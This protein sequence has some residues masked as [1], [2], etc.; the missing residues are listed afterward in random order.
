MTAIHTHIFILL[1][2][3]S[4]V[5]VIW[6]AV[7]PIHPYNLKHF[8]PAVHLRILHRIKWLNNSERWTGKMWPNLKYIPAF[9]S[10]HWGKAR[11]T[12]VRIFGVLA[13]IRTRHLPT[14][15]TRKVTAWPNLFGNLIQH[16]RFPKLV[17]KFSWHVQIKHNFDTKVNMLA[18][19]SVF[20]YSS[21]VNQAHGLTE[22]LDAYSVKVTQAG[23]KYFVSSAVNFNTKAL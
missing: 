13:N 16:L 2:N 1:L 15:Q 23:G 14:T 12:S 10:R 7:Y 8:V 5:P 4:H 22:N 9:A 11:K 3:I 19:Q 18:L 20:C 17:A 21:N 6:Q